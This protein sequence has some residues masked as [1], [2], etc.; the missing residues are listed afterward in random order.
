MKKIIFCKNQKDNEI[1]YNLKL[2]LN[3]INYEKKI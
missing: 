2:L 1:N 3:N